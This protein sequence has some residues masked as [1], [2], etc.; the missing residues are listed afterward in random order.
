MLFFKKQNSSVIIHE[1]VKGS[2]D[3][4][5]DL[6]QMLI[7][8]HLL[9][10]NIQQMRKPGKIKVFRVTSNSG[11]INPA[12]QIHTLT[13]IST[14]DHLKVRD[15]SQ[16]EEGHSDGC[17]LDPERSGVMGNSGSIGR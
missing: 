3:S 5:N 1:L 12:V 8:Y 15:R 11:S 2:V 4:L 9:A 17:R 14:R 7:T 10:K 13:I 6:N 16:G